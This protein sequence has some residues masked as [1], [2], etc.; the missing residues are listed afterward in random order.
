MNINTF[1]IICILTS[2]VFGAIGIFLD[3]REEIKKK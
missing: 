3:F 1:I 2:I